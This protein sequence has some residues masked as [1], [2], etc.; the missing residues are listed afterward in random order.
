MYVSGNWSLK[1]GKLAYQQGRLPGL[2]SR[3]AKSL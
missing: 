1:S 3:A 2:E